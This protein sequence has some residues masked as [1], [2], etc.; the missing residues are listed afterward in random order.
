MKEFE[1]KFPLM[2]IGGTTKGFLGEYMAGGLVIVLGLKFLNDGSIAECDGPITGNELGTGIHR[3]KII[4]RTD[5]ELE[6]KLG[7]GAKIYEINEYEIKQI[8]KHLEEFCSIFNIPI[9]ILLNKPFKVVNPYRR[10]LLAHS[11]VVK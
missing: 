2:I 10:D 4:L 1:N 9:E 7:V 8:K 3:G 5:E 6:S 11:I